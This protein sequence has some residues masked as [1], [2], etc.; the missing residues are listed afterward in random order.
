MLLLS[1][2]ESLTVICADHILVSPSP[3]PSLFLS[4]HLP[5]HPLSPIAAFLYLLHIESSLVDCTTQV[6]LNLLYSIKLIGAIL[7]RTDH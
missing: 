6:T 4:L 2:C 3:S 7:Y 1:S 5:L